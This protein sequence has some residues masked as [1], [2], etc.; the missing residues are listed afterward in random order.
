MTLGW[1]RTIS[2]QP[3]SRFW[4]FQLFEAGLFV[5]L[6]LVVVAVAVWFIRRTPA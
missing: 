5:L 6:A 3:D 1:R 2:Y 4:T